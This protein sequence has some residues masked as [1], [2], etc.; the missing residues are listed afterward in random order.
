DPC[1]DGLVRLERDAEHV[2]R[3]EN[4]GGV[5][6]VREPVCIAAQ[7]RASSERCIESR[8]LLVEARGSALLAAAQR[9]VRLRERVVPEDPESRERTIGGIRGE[10]RGLGVALLEVL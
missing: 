5:R 2:A 4:P 10:E 9:V 7:P 3:A 6:D 1:G 8:E